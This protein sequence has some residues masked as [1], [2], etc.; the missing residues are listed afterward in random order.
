MI[1]L[2]TFQVAVL[3][4]V[5]VCWQT[6]ILE[7]RFTFDRVFLDLALRNSLP[8]HSFRSSSPLTHLNLFLNV[9]CTFRFECST[10][11]LIPC[12]WSHPLPIFDYVLLILSLPTSK[13]RERRLRN[14]ILSCAEGSF[15]LVLY[16]FA[17]YGEG[18]TW[19]RKFTWLM[20]DVSSVQERH[21]TISSSRRRCSYPRQ[22]LGD[23]IYNGFG[24]NDENFSMSFPLP[25]P[26]PPIPEGCL[27]RHREHHLYKYRD[28]D[29]S[30]SKELSRDHRAL[31]SSHEQAE[32]RDSQVDVDNP[33]RRKHGYKVNLTT[34]F[35]H[36]FV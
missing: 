5:N 11:L 25:T 13:E 3:L 19:N 4:P 15:E 23:F 16:L 32:P 30:F 17:L 14:K 6:V 20:W 9:Q 27:R 36:L 12:L 34:I 7:L 28:R 10:H 31:I 2:H 35:Y 18:S 24:P 22:G 26:R 21:P 8:P 1:I 33:H 29:R